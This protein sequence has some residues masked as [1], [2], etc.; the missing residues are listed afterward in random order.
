MGYIL[1]A[2]FGLICLVVLLTFLSR[3]ASRPRTGQP[4]PSEA[5]MVGPDR[6]AAE[7]V[8]PDRSATAAKSQIEAAREHTP[9]A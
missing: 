7:T 4:A 5:P 1:A 9:P 6:P 2:I 3:S 8:T